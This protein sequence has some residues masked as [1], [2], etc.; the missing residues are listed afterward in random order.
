MHVCPRG[1][2]WDPGASRC[3]SG[4]ASI[5]L[6]IEE[7]RP[8]GPPRSSAQCH[9]KELP[10]PQGRQGQ[11]SSHTEPSCRRH[12]CLEPRGSSTLL[13]HTPARGTINSPSMALDRCSHLG[14]RG[15][16]TGRLWPRSDCG[17][18]FAALQHSP[19]SS[20][21]REAPPAISSRW[22]CGDWCGTFGHWLS[23]LCGGLG[24]GAGSR[25]PSSLSFSQRGRPSV[26]HTSQ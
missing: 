22:R 11:G 21:R 7:G 16:L 5:S 3:T 26:Q 2:L 19:A 6:G 15:P 20:P 14:H 18:G 8:L 17:V 4:S 23:R 12:S 13:H 9:P 24:D 25:S 1:D 10:Q